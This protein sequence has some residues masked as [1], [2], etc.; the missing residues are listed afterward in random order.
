MAETGSGEDAGGGTGGS[1]GKDKRVWVAVLP[2]WKSFLI[3][4]GGSLLMGL[5]LA[6]ALPW[7]VVYRLD[8]NLSVAVITGWV[9][10]IPFYALVML[11]LWKNAYN[12]RLPVL[13]HLA[14]VYAVVTLLFVTLMGVSFI[15]GSLD[16]FAP[17]S[18]GADKPVAG[19]P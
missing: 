9:F 14:R 18:S 6:I 19:K 8:W 7:L 3:G 4:L 5:V 2:L 17:S 16:H 1:A 10:F 13:G 12:T 15:M 11:S